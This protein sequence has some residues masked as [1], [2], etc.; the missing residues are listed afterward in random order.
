MELGSFEQTGKLLLDIAAVVR[1]H[2]LP[3]DPFNLTLMVKAQP[4]PKHFYT[5]NDL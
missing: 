1:E 3:W 4:E 2:G 5:P